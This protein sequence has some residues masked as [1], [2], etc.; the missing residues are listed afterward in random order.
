MLQYSSG[1]NYLQSLVAYSRFFEEKL[2]GLGKSLGF[3]VFYKSSQ[4]FGNGMCSGTFAPSRCVI[5][6]KIGCWEAVS[7][8][9]ESCL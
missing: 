2:L 5:S 1:R 7:S 3:V 9:Q 4:E 6:I 8:F